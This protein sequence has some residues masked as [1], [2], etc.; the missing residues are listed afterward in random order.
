MTRPVGVESSHLRMKDLEG[1]NNVTVS[2]LP[3]S[4]SRDG[5]D[6]FFVNGSRC[7]N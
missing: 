3:Q 1:D 5:F 2:P 4:S 7:P 6:Q